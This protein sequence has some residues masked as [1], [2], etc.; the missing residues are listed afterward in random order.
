MQ[1]VFITLCHFILVKGGIVLSHQSTEAR[2]RGSNI[3]WDVFF[4]AFL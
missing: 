4:G 1:G 3:L 2:G